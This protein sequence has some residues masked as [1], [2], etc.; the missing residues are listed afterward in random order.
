MELLSYRPRNRGHDYYGRVTGQD[1]PQGTKDL[2]TRACGWWNF[3]NIEQKSSK[4]AG[5]E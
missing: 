2:Y 4:A 3:L 5:L 1:V